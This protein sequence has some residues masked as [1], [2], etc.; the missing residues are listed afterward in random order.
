MLCPQFTHK[1]ALFWLS[2]IQIGVFITELAIG[3]VQ[4]TSFLAADISTLESMGQKVSR[5]SIKRLR[6]IYL[7]H[8][9]LWIFR[10]RI[11]CAMILRSTVSCSQ[12]SCM[13]I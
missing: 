5:N 7:P 3:G 4:Q 10:T 9:I 2:L 1:S 12:S 13:V 6:D 11:E 8:I